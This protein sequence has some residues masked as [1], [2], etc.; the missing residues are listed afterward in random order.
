M[1]RV[2]HRYVLTEVVHEKK[3]KDM[4]QLA[5]MEKKDILKIL[6]IHIVDLFGDTGVCK[7]VSNFQIKYWNPS[8]GILIIRVGAKNVDMVHQMLPWITSLSTVICKVKTI[9]T[10]ATLKLIESKLK[11]VNAKFCVKA[12]PE[13]D[14]Q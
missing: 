12:D 13:E 4:K 5:S 10:S 1:V 8:T 7:I 2:K 3:T 6:K 11:K 9:H 14:S